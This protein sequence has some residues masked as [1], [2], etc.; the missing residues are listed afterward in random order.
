MKREVI[1]EVEDEGR[2]DVEIR[3]ACLKEMR[4]V[5]QISERN[6]ELLRSKRPIELQSNKIVPVTLWVLGGAI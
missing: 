3:L 6:A 2:V 5:I 1:E 4:Q